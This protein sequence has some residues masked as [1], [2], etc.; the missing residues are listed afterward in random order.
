MI[1]WK[2]WRGFSS[3]CY[4]SNDTMYG[5]LCLTQLN[6]MNNNQQVATNVIC[7][8]RGFCFSTVLEQSM[9]IMTVQEMTRM[10]E[11]STDFNMEDVWPRGRLKITLGLVVDCQ[12]QQ[13]TIDD[14]M[15]CSK[16]QKLK[17][18]NNI[19]KDRTV[20]EYFLVF[21]HP[22]FPGFRAIEWIV[23]LLFVVYMVILVTSL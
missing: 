12:T 8:A 4:G 18:L 15:D 21:A 23:L 11:K 3:K 2:Y 10:S 22:G 20:S 9:I 19:H 6:E 17:I 1:V 16:C 7:W 5:I 14:V 13:L